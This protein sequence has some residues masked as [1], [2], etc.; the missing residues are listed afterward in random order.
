MENLY[1]GKKVLVLGLAK[2]GFYAAKLLD[3]LG[4]EVIVNDK[5]DLRKDPKLEELNKLGI[6]VILGGHPA[7]LLDKNFDILVKNPGIP[8]E[9]KIIQEAQMKNIPVVTEVEIASEVAKG[10]FIGITGTNG[11]TTTTTI[12]QKMLAADRVEGM[13]YVSGNIGVPVSQIA[14]DTKEADD[15]VVEL[16]SFQLLGTP[17]IQPEI[18]VIT[19]I[20]AAHIDYHGSRE[21]Y[22]E[23][24][25]NLI[26]NQEKDDLLIYNADQ[27]DLEKILKERS[28]AKMLAFSRKRYLKDGVSVKG[29]SIYYKEEK[30]AELSDIFVK[31]KHNIENFLAAIAVAKSKKVG[32]QSIQ[33]VMR[34]F[35]GVKHRT[36][37]LLEWNERVFYNDSKATNI[38]A[39]EQALSGFEQP[40]ILLAGGLD[41]GDCYEPLIP[42][43]KEN[44]KG[45]VLFGETAEKLKETA[46]DA[47]I[48]KIEI[49]NEMD[50]AVKTAY[51]MSS[52]GDVIL[53]SPAAASWD[54]YKNFE[55]RGDC[56]IDAVD[57]LVK[58]E[59]E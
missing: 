40:I 47:G 50:K 55:V 56:F 54:Q 43:I 10:H 46:K 12:I 52:E 9:N 14:L 31:G 34:E 42:Y 27:E 16:S 57:K 7:D 38:E 2:S 35:K 8:Y 32:N 13:A 28:K 36:Q 23:A 29:Q 37:F 26:K 39:T 4:A 45:L 48:T 59:D 33:K 25:L 19:N 15:L 53:L 18:A 6:Q 1:Q 41:R 58:G 30:V 11:K 49:I 5:K 21:A 22:L 51:Q 17:R 20:T 24:K 3:Q 44:V